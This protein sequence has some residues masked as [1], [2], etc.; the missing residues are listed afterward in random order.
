[1][2]VHLGRALRHRNFRLFFIGQGVSLIG[3][4]LTSFATVW[5]VYRLTHS[6]LLLGLVAFFGQAPAAVIAPLAGVLVDRWDRHRVIIATQIAA[7]LQSAALAVFALTG[8]MTVWHL[9]VLGAVQAVINGFDVPARQSFLRE[10]VEDRADLPNAIALN[11]SMFNCARMIGPVIAAALVTW[12]GEGYCFAIDAFSYLAVVTSLLAV[13]VAKR[14][15]RPRRHV[16]IEM[17]EGWHYVVGHPLVRAV[18]LLVSISSLLGGAYGALLP[19]IAHLAK[20]LG[21]LMAGSGLGALSG[22]LYLANRRSVVGLGTVIARSVIVL[23]GSMIALRVAPGVW[24]ATAVMFVM[25]A[26]IMIQM[27]SSNTILQTVVDPD[28]IGRVMSLYTMTLFTFVPLGALLLGTFADRIGVLDTFS[29]AG[30]VTITAGL[31]FM[32][33]LPKIRIVAPLDRRVAA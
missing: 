11:S 27:A 33:A 26:A 16:W 28:R 4:G 12:V 2:V 29:V 6:G 3:T 19:L 20:N 22:A 30:V 25:G 18:L 17:K 24:L 15:P 23:G 31:V 32:R 1:M 10:L 9:M 13:R 8:H 21:I 14:P 7:M 5:M